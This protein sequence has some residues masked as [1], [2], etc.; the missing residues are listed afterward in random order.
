MKILTATIGSAVWLCFMLAGC[1]GLTTSDVGKEEYQ[2]KCATC[3]GA[4]GKGDGPQAQFLP[5]KPA[6][7]TKLAKNNGGVFPVSR[8]HEIIDGRLEVAAHGPR[9]MPVW[10][11]EFLFDETRH[12]QDVSPQA[13]SDREARVNARVQALV[14]YLSRLQD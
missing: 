13:F 2:S 12:S 6:D 5:N 10:G 3:H 11:D 8:I 14:D 7:L 4:G 9:L 1:A